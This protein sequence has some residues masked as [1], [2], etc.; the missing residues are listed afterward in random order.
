MDEQENNFEQEA[1]L[2]GWV[3]KDRFRGNED[4]WIDAET[5]VKRGK[6]I[7]PILKK[8]NERLMAELEKNKRDLAELRATTETFKT[9]QKDH[10]ERKTQELELQIRQLKEQKKEAIKEG[11]G[12]LVLE[13]EDQIDL[14]KEQQL[15]N[16]ELPVV[17]PEKKQDNQP[18]QKTLEWIDDHSWYKTDSRLQAITDAL[19]I[20]LRQQKPYLTEDQFFNELDSVIE[21]TINDPKVNK[22]Q[23]V[24]KVEG[25]SQNNSGGSSSSV[26]K[27][28]DSLPQDAK[29][30][31]DRF[32]RQKLM[33]QEQYIQTYFDLV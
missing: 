6:E 2:Q 18:S 21:E 14:I 1:S 32:V 27:Q 9:F 33:T 16:K 13:I 26:K 22:K 7:N 24:S 10:Y 23:N 8:N 31:C 20:Q 3:P 15:Q 25:R 17:I 19:A 12:S 11:D 4:D 28:Y 5:F 29:I 30:A